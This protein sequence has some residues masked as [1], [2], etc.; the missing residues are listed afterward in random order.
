[1]LT[2]TSDLPEE[3]QLALRTIDAKMLLELKW[4]MTHALT[5]HPQHPP[6]VVSTG[7]CEDAV[8]VVCGTK[9]YARL[10]VLQKEA[11]GLYATGMADVVVNKMKAGA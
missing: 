5:A 4:A 8:M 11:Q 6:V 9:L 10:Q 1:M 3:I 7:L 2:D